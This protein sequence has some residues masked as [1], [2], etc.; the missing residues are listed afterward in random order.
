MMA[1]AL[2]NE[3]IILYVIRMGVGGIFSVHTG[4]QGEKDTLKK[5][6]ILRA[7]YYLL[8]CLFWQP[9]ELTLA[10]KSHNSWIREKLNECQST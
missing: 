10:K 1:K 4:L 8:V 2:Q 3:T 6:L 9:T 5:L 7:C